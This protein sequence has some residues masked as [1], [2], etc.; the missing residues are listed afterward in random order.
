MFYVVFNNIFKGN[1]I[2]E[3]FLGQEGFNT[4]DVSVEYLLVKRAK[5][6]IVFEKKMMQKMIERMYLQAKH[7]YQEELEILEKMH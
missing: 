4:D 7:L 5:E 1:D 3:H 2:H 6:N